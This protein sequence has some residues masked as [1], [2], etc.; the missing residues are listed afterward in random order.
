MMKHTLFSGTAL[1]ALAFAGPAH[2]Q[3]YGGGD[4]VTAPADAPRGG[5]S[6]DR[7]VRVDPYIE[8]AQ[9]L[10][11]ELS[12]GD[13]VLTFTQ[14]AAGVDASIQGRNNGGSVS[15]RYERS[16]GWGDNARDSDTVSG[17]ARGYVSVVPQAVTLQAGALAARTRV[18]GDGSSS[19]SPVIEDNNSSRIYSVYAGP[20]L[21]TNAGDVFV[22][23]NYQL[24]YT[25]IES[26]DALVT[27]PGVDPVDVFDESVS[28]SAQLQLGIAPGE[29]LPVGLAV[30][31]GFR[32][33]DISNLDQRVRDMYVRG[34]V[35]VPVGRTVN[36]VGGVGY[37]DVEVSSRDA[38]LDGAGVP[39]LGDDGRLQ[40]DKS[41][42]RQLAYDVSGLIW[43][44]GVVWRPSSRTVLEANVGKRYDSTT[45]YGSFAWAPDN[46]SAFNVSVYDG[47]AGFGGL[48][49]SALV[50]LPTDFEANR[51]PLTGDLNG[52]VATLE[53]GGCLSGVL[54]SVRSSVFRSRG[55]AATYSRNLGILSAGIGA[56][57][58]RR[59]YIA[60]TGTVLAAANGIVDENYWVN[61]YLNGELGRSASFATNAYINWFDSGFNNAGDATVMGASAAYR[62]ALGARISA[63]AAVALDHIDSQIDAEDLTA[64]SALVGLRYDF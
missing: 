18:D 17:V 2:A 9:V 42:P 45:Y 36:L 39:I 63:K 64:A 24:G 38:I 47:I 11:A 43:D 59:K 37:E 34:D 23:G 28:Q 53:G 61:A 4:E 1:V 26:P 21:S 16:F 48:I 5:Q 13:E 10:V 19:L 30:G 50:D 12:P 40:T 55:V 52:C 20:T 25:R 29:P 14:V 60:S 46:R 51:N 54:G 27:A 32:Q 56:G 41:Q 49:N 57:F 22:N 62:R 31:G 35:T 7:Q 58:D 8:A 15:L 44:V 3:S 33:E 6:G